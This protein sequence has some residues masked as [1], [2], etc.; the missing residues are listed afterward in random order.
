M[1]YR[2]STMTKIGPGR[3]VYPN[4]PVGCPN[5]SIRF[6][7]VS[8]FSHPEFQPDSCAFVPLFGASDSAQTIERAMPKLFGLESHL[9]RSQFV[10]ETAQVDPPV[11]FVLRS[12][13]D[14]SYSIC[15][16]LFLGRRIPELHGLD[17]LIISY[18]IIQIQQLSLRIS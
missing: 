15:L 12:F 3:G 7:M 14:A 4:P 5:C 13:H 6:I 16:V 11:R 1:T 8:L 2:A 10:R 9:F 18:I 17:R